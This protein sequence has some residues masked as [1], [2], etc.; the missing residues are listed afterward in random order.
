MPFTRGLLLSAVLAVV[1]CDAPR[2]PL[3]QKI[4]DAPLPQKLAFPAGDSTFERSGVE[5]WFLKEEVYENK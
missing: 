1:A 5:T 3:A 2:P 4:V